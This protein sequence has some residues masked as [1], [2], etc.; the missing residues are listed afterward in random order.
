[1]A[2]HRKTIKVSRSL[3]LPRQMGG[4][5]RG[6]AIANGTLTLLLCYSSMTLAF[7][8]VGIV[9]HW[10]LRWLSQKDPWWREIMLVY[11][12]YPDIYE[13]MPTTKFAARFKRPYGFDQDLPC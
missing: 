7:L 4:A 13:P 3:S 6:L 12:R 5:D 1:M 11:N 9:G 2:S 8:P 10:L